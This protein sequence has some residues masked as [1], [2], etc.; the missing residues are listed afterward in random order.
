VIESDLEGALVAVGGQYE[1][2]GA[3]GFEGDGEEAAGVAGDGGALLAV[4]EVQDARLVAPLKLA[5]PL[6]RRLLHVVHLHRRTLRLGRRRHHLPLHVV[7]LQ[8]N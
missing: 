5:P 2:E 7:P 1:G 8:K 3:E 6:L 4:E